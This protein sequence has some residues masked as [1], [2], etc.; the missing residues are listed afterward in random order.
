LRA[1]VGEERYRQIIQVERFAA[2]DL[3]RAFGAPESGGSRQGGF[4]THE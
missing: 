3:Q 2:F 1:V 4:I